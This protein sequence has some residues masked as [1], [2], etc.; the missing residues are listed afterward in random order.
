[1]QA[2]TPEE[3]AAKRRH[4]AEAQL[5]GL[6]AVLFGNLL[7]ALLICGAF[8]DKVD[9]WKLVAWLALVATVF[10]PRL[11]QR[12]RRWP[13][14]PSGYR[15][16]QW[17]FRMAVQGVAAAAAWVV[18][19]LLIGAPAAAEEIVLAFVILALNAVT[20]AGHAFN[21]GFVRG[22]CLAISI[23]YIARYTTSGDATL[24]LVG[25]LMLPYVGYLLT[26][27]IAASRR[28]MR[29]IR[30]ELQNKHLTSALADV[31]QRL[32]EQVDELA[33]SKAAAEVNR[34]EALLAKEQAENAT[35]AKSQF[36]AHMS[37]EL[38]TPLNAIIGFSAVMKDQ[39]LGP[40]GSQ[41]YLEYAADI[42][43]SG[44]H[45]LAVINDVLDTAK[46]EA[47]QFV[48]NETACKVSDLI[49]STVRMVANEAKTRNL[50]LVIEAGDA[51]TLWADERAVRQMLLNLLSNA[52][53]FTGSGGHI[54]VRSA[55]DES[56]RLR[57]TVA[58]S[59]IG[60][61]AADLDQVLRPFG[62]AKDGIKLNNSGT[63]LGLSL[64]K[65]LIEIHDGEL[66]IDSTPGVGTDITLVF[67]ASR[68]D[69]QR[70]AQ[71]GA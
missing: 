49:V 50:A 32:S 45:L 44:E 65:N 29:S 34:H 20:F 14:I 18:P 67:P 1:M 36:L 55:R 53:K 58:D 25:V 19:Q 7:T 70:T 37:H 56:G 28:L 13:D 38:R 41:R 16:G 47:G 59:G 39:L 66:Q 52:I 3:Q 15:F 68:V 22:Y 63:G 64:T 48:L 21:T 30:H 5:G 46:I 43:G 10:H 26:F 9:T 61:A 71:K 2:L 17:D 60:I 57:L 42:H 33:R 69:D 51:I 12:M 4:E 31:N 23:P 54:T 8:Y 40:V 27:Q 6:H 62:Q 35:R 24:T 11:R